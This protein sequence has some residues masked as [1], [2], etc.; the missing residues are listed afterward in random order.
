MGSWAAVCKHSHNLAPM[1]APFGKALGR[2][3]PGTVQV[4]AQP[5]QRL[6]AQLPRHLAGGC[7]SGRQ[8]AGQAVEGGAHQQ[9][10]ADAA[11]QVV[12]WVAPPPGP[13]LRGL[14]ISC[15]LLGAVIV[16]LRCI[17]GATQTR[18]NS[19]RQRLHRRAGCRRN[20]GRREP[21]SAAL[22]CKAV[23]VLIGVVD[24]VR[25]QLIGVW[26]KGA[27]ASQACRRPQDGAAAQERRRARQPTLQRRRGRCPERSD[28]PRSDPRLRPTPGRAPVAPDQKPCSPAG[29]AVALPRAPGAA[30]PA[31][32]AGAGAER[33]QP[34]LAV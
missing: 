11:A 23:L 16:S 5:L 24:I 14:P 13:L 19:R 17:L 7:D 10:H 27:G 21:G 28:C 15:R 12:T 29:P 9:Q 22:S 6:A 18:R 34:P 32:D 20:G 2:L 1:R 4:V 3:V 30:G 31:P 33:T 25:V 8:P 26:V